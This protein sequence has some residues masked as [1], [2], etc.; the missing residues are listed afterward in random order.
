MSSTSPKPRLGTVLNDGTL[1]LVA[2][3]ILLVAAVLWSA[4]SPNAERT[5]FALTYV[6]AHIVHS[7][8]GNRLYDT[9]LQIRLRN[10]MFQ[11]ASP[12]YFEHPPFEAVILAPLAS[13][14]YRTA[15]RIWGLINVTV[16]LAMIVWLRPYLQWPSEDLSY[17]FLWLLFAP[18]GIALYQGQSSIFVLAAY[19]ISFV[20]LKKDHPFAAGAAFGVGLLKFQFAVPMALVFLFRRQWRFLGGFAASG[21]VLGCISLLGIGPK[22]VLQYIRLLSTIGAN[23]ENVSYG[24][25]VDMPT[26]Q[27]LTYAVGGRHLSTLAVGILVLLLSIAL[28]L[29]IAL[30]WQ[31]R[32]STSV[33]PMFAAALPASLL[34]GVHMFAHDLSPLI[35]SMLLAASHCDNLSRTLR[36]VLAVTLIVFWAFPAYFLFVR[37][38]CLYVIATAMIVLTYVCVRGAETS[39]PQHDSIVRAVPAG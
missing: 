36:R 6:G 33:D 32:E 14:P 34:S 28:L 23:P 4:N 38:H 27:G 17:L 2:L 24:S 8:M 18:I 15:Y 10:S 1:G 25:A 19:G 29:W 7:G 30:R 13:L 35:L 31:A 11:H 26:L 3:A 37:W 16:L 9:G 22:G 5:D 20:A 12:L 39:A 21:L